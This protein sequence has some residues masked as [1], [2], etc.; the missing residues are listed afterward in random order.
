MAFVTVLPLKLVEIEYARISDVAILSGRLISNSANV[1]FKNTSWIFVYL[2]A[3]ELSEIQNLLFMGH[4]IFEYLEGLSIDLYQVNINYELSEFSE[5][6]LW[7]C[8]GK[9]AEFEIWN[10]PEEKK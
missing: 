6:Q 8:R 3:R 10:F 9:S 5:H 7:A 2:N 1:K 4:E